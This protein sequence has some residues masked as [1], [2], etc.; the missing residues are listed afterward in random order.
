MRKSTIILLELKANST[1][2]DFQHKLL[3]LVIGLN[4]K[5]INREF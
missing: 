1:A 5:Y 3:P 2:A 4:L